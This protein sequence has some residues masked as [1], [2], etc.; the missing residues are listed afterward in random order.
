MSRTYFEIFLEMINDE[1]PL[2]TQT[3]MSFYHKLKLE[4]LPELKSEIN[5]RLID[6]DKH[7]RI[8]YLEYLLQ[9]IDNQAYV[10]DAGINYI[11]EHLTK[12]NVSLQTILDFDLNALPH[13][14]RYQVLDIHYKDMKPFSKEKDTAFLVQLD[15]MNY[16]CKLVTDQ[17]IE[18]CKNKIDINKYNTI[19]GKSTGVK[20]E[21]LE[22]FNTY[23]GLDISEMHDYAYHKYVQQNLE[24]AIFLLDKEIKYNLLILDN[25]KLDIYFD[26][27]IEML[28]SSQFMKFEEATMNVYIEKYNLDL[29]SFPKVNN[30]E[31]SE[32]LRL[33]GDPYNPLHGSDNKIYFDAEQIQSNFYEYTAKLEIN[34]FIEIVKALQSKYLG[35]TAIVEE[36]KALNYNSNLFISRESQQWFDDTL[37]ELNATDEKNNAKTGFQAKANAIFTDNNCKKVIFKYG[38]LLKEYITFLNTTFN[39]G[40]K[41][42]NKLSD[43]VKHTTRVE[44]LI[45]LYQNL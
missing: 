15:F 14:F 23:S 5:K 10:K 27:L 19:D 42:D 32:L 11:Q 25:S 1:D 37:T 45:A 26:Q 2:S 33:T 43:G 17:L 21:L 7:T 24:K 35:V 36:K 40:I 22:N 6:T 20:N 38:L 34:K 9:E 29:A 16:F 12:Y 18:F 28:Q 13:Q 39:A 30:A 41:S 3:A 31:L 4:V 44:E 8:P